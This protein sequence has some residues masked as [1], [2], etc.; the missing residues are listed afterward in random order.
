MGD[1]SSYF[2]FATAAGLTAAAVVIALMSA[3]AHFREVTA[4]LKSSARMLG[5]VEVVPSEIS[6][7]SSTTS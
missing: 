5:D 4:T 1:F 6:S 7:E 2:F 3:V